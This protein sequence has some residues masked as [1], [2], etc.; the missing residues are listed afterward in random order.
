M[1]W[2][3]DLRLFGL[4]ASGGKDANG[5]GAKRAQRCFC[6]LH[7]QCDQFSAKRAILEVEAHYEAPAMLGFMKTQTNVD[8]PIAVSLCPIQSPPTPPPVTTCSDDYT[9]LGCFMDSK[10]DRVMGHKLTDDENTTADVRKLTL[11]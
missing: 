4:S 8:N 10:E 3:T 11:F 1:I 5:R 6:S 9:H 7:E 2:R